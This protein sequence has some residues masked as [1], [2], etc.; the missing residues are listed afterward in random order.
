VGRAIP[1]LTQVRRFLL[2]A[3]PE[4][5][6]TRGAEES[7]SPAT[8]GDAPLPLF[9]MATM[10]PG[11]FSICRAVRFSFLC[12]LWRVVMETAAL[13]ADGDA[14]LPLFV[15]ATMLRGETTRALSGNP[16]QAGIL[17]QSGQLLHV[18]HR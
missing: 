15:M 8:D 11:E 13:A 17:A 12:P 4:E 10:L 18:L 3:F 7:A 9:V 5:Y 2:K 1:V 16:N 6:A 14:P